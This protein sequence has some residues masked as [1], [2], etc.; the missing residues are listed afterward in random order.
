M[1]QFLRV[2]DLCVSVLP[3]YP[4]AV[5]AVPLLCPGAR[6]FSHH[7]PSTLVTGASRYALLLVP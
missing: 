6:S 2:P 3:G 1:M 5:Y 4:Q 7:P